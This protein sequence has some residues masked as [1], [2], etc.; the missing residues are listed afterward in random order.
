LVII[1]DHSATPIQRRHFLSKLD[2]LAAMV[3]R[4][5]AA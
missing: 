3:R 4:L 5:Q 2:D 1:L